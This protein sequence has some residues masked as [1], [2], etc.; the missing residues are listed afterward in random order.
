MYIIY[1]VPPDN[2]CAASLNAQDLRVLHPRRRYR[3]AW[4]PEMADP[5]GKVIPL[6]D[7]GV[8][9]MVRM[10]MAMAMGLGR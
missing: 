4:S 3:R 10:S 8:A 6:V 9:I 2:E 5:R 1:I 7:V